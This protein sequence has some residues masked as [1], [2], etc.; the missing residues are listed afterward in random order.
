MGAFRVGRCRHTANAMNRLLP[1]SLFVV[2]VMLFGCSKAQPGSGD[3]RS[4]SAPGNSNKVE[5]M[6]APRIE[7]ASSRPPPAKSSA[8]ISIASA[9]QYSR[10]FEQ[11]FASGGLNALHQTPDV[12]KNPEIARLILEK[13]QK[14]WRDGRFWSEMPIVVMSA[15]IVSTDEAAPSANP[16]ASQIGA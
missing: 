8:V 4:A 3:D 9:A 10:N 13:F 2:G 12:L 14:E 6:A 5:S 15:V 7:P 1:T 11:L 16:S